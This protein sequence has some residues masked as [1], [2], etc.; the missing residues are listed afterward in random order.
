MYYDTATKIIQVTTFIDGKPAAVISTDTT[1]KKLDIETIKACLPG[2]KKRSRVSLSKGLLGF[3]KSIN[4][5]NYELPDM[6]I[7]RMAA[8]QGVPYTAL[9]SQRQQ[10]YA[11]SVETYDFGMMRNSLP[12]NLQL[13]NT[14]QK[15]IVEGA[16]EKAQED[17]FE[18]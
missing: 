6:L 3:I 17:C 4:I 11:K 14:P 5:Y 13:V 12:K 10:A 18:Q 7:N 16:K 2:N 15:I 9:D 1:D 8:N